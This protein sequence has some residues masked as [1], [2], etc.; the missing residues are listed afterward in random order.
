MVG[1]GLRKH[2]GKEDCLV[3]DIVDNFAKH[4]LSGAS[5]SLLGLTSE[6]V[7]REGQ[8]AS[9]PVEESEEDIAQ[10]VWEGVELGLVL[11]L[12]GCLE[13]GRMGFEQPILQTLLDVERTSEGVCWDLRTH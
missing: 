11:D 4:S 8:P 3:L 9:D 13:R 2:P 1:R 5:T 7:D 12:G 10:K 6:V